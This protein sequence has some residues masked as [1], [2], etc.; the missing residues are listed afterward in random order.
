MSL[1]L[2][3]GGDG[4]GRRGKSRGLRRVEVGVIIITVPGHAVVS[5]LRAHTAR[6]RNEPRQLELRM[7]KT[8]KG[9][10]EGDENE[11]REQSQGPSH[12]FPERWREKHTAERKARV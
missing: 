3:P 10:R 12:G 5:L 9:R 1:K 8:N 4:D 11:E 7:V 6:R 2:V